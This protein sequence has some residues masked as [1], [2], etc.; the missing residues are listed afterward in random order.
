MAGEI[1]VMIHPVGEAQSAV[2][3]TGSVVA[4]DWVYA[5]QTSTDDLFAAARGDAYTAGSVFVA[6]LAVGANDGYVVGIALNNAGSNET[7]S[8]ATEGTFI[9]VSTGTPTAG[10]AV[11]TTGQGLADYNNDASG[12][13]YIVG[14]ALTGASA[15]AKYLLFKLSV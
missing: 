4:G 12:A 14:R 11:M 3:A 5:Y 10:K 1:N 13:G 6:R 2:V 15:A 9:G 8:V 7:V